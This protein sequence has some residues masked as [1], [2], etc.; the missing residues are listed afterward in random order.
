MLCHNVYWQFL[1]IGMRISC[2]FEHVHRQHR[3]ETSVRELFLGLTSRYLGLCL[4]HPDRTP[5]N[6][7]TRNK[8][9]SLVA[10]GGNLAAGRLVAEG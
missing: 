2:R 3:M 4:W 9:R 7:S 6:W 10:T 8:R 1:V 5:V